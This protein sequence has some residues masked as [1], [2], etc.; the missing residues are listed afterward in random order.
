MLCPVVN[1]FTLII[2]KHGSE[3]NPVTLAIATGKLSALALCCPAVRQQSLLLP[4]SVQ[5]IYYWN[6]L[7]RQGDYLQFG[8][9]NEDAE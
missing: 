7:Q 9:S 5:T 8:F 1:S 2:K 4:G 6:P 3:G